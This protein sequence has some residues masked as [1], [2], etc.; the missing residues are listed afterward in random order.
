MKL[1]PCPKVRSS[2]SE[3]QITDDT[4][5]PVCRVRGRAAKEAGWAREA[6]KSFLMPK[7]GTLS[8]P[9]PGLCWAS[10]RHRGKITDV[11]V[12]MVWEVPRGS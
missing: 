2:N 11:A 1:T 9:S 10:V 3:D 7:T 5:M 6:P 4:M 8:N 12:R